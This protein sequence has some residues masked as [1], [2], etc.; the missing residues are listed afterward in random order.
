MQQKL[1]VARITGSDELRDA[2]EVEFG[3]LFGPRGV[4]G[5]QLLKMKER[6][7]LRVTGV[8]S[9]VL[10]TLLQKDRFDPALIDL[11]IQGRLIGGSFLHSS[12]SG[13]LRHGV[14]ANHTERSCHD[15][16]FQVTLCH[17]RSFPPPAAKAAG[18]RNLHRLRS[19]KYSF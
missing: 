10:A 4:P 8:T 12:Q 7:I 2:P 14:Q 16:Y 18:I 1:A 11:K 9:G 13:R 15:Q 3:L 5:Q 6:F 19:Q 17:Y